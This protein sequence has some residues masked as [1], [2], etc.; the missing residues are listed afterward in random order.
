MA[1]R[2]LRHQQRRCGLP[3]A[4][5]FGRQNP[6]SSSSPPAAAAEEQLELELELEA[7]R[8]LQLQREAATLAATLDLAESSQWSYELSLG[9][10]KTICRQFEARRRFSTVIRAILFRQEDPAR[11]GAEVF[12]LLRWFVK[13]AA[14]ER[15]SEE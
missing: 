1:H 14:E 5:P 3:P 8:S 2:H 15:A 11:C 9:A 4:R 6:S 7:P 10:V 12:R 13:S